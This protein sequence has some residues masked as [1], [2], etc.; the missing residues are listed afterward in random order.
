MTLLNCLLMQ[1]VDCLFALPNCAPWGNNSR[2]SSEEYREKKRAEET[3]TLT[4]LAVACIFQILLG[5]KYLIENSGYSDIFTKSPLQVL[6]LLPYFMA[7]FDQCTFGGILEGEFIRKRSHFEGSHVLHH[8]QKLC[9]G[10]HKHFNLR[11]KGRAAAAARYP[12]QECEWIVLDAQTTGVSEGGRILHA[13]MSWDEKVKT[14]AVHGQ[15]QRLDSGMG[16]HS[17]SMA[18]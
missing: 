3:A 18:P 5:W 13:Q 15:R 4:F 17:S 12:E 9:T 16:Q 8:L 7:L 2:A 10:G 1:G 11:G 6:R 14:P